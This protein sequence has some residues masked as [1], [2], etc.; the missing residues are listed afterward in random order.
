MPAA[1]VALLTVALAAVAALARP[2]LAFAAVLAATVLVPDTLAL[3]TGVTSVLTV[4]LVVL[5][6]ALGGQAW[7]MLAGR[8]DPA[9]WR[10]TG[11]SLGLAAYLVVALLVGLSFAAPGVSVASGSSRAVDLLQQLAALVVCTGLIREDGDPFGFVMPTIAILMTSVG[12]GFIEHVTGGSWGHFLFS[13]LPSQSNTPAAT[14]LQTRGNA[15]RIRAGADFALSYA[16]VLVA[17]LSMLFVAALLGRGA[18]RWLLA[19]GGVLSLVAIY[20]S[21]SRSA[22]L[23]LVVMVLVLGLLARRAA[24][25]MTMIGLV[26]VVALAVLAL[27][28]LGHHFSA[29]IDQGSINVREQ[30]L[31]IILGAVSQRPF[32]G[33]G[34]S[35]LSLLGISAVDSTYLLVYG[36]TGVIGLAALLG[37][38]V[39]TFWSIGRGLK[40]NGDPAY[41]VLAAGSMAGILAILA[42]GVA[43]D[44]IDLPSV[45]DVI[46]ILA[47]IGLVSAEV[48]A[49]PAR[50]LR[51]VPTL[52]TATL[53]AAVVGVL[54]AALVPTHQATSY[55]FFTMPTL[56]EVGSGDLSL[57]GNTLIASACGVITA[58]AA[59]L[60]GVSVSCR[61]PY[62]ATGQG[63]FT[64]QAGSSRQ[65][66]TA[67]A[68]LQAAAAR[69]G[70]HYYRQFA[71]TSPT[72]GRDSGVVTL[73]T[74][75]AMF[76]F[77]VAF[78]AP[79]TRRERSA[80]GRFNPA[81]WRRGAL[82][83]SAP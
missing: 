37:A 74:S 13:R 72:Q 15:V 18:K 7:R 48:S 69:A 62:Q 40:G 41:R 10:P 19:A 59:H 12:I 1:A 4:H 56:D 35:G 23:A 3:P 77:V 5:I 33:L 8:T 39:A 51:P 6:G 66:V 31:P 26:I 52:V 49:G 22:L 46:W 11:A 80:S 57:T 25:T 70:L 14:P 83:P 65:I 53:A 55:T 30:R 21:G 44:V 73:P 17:L 20:W 78:A 47:A 60:P 42:G 43:L 2:R 16:I 64:V 45:A 82:A 27:P 68:Q 24:V 32:T 36:E 28:A 79:L 61:N 34:L 58:E 75:L 38:M 54:P 76:A 29:G 67:A 81:T 71:L 9:V 63:L 50:L